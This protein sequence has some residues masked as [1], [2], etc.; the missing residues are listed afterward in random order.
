MI[1]GKL[2]Y[3]E[4]SI[5][6]NYCSS[7]V[8]EEQSLGEYCLAIDHYYNQNYLEGLEAYLVSK[9]MFIF[10]QHKSLLMYPH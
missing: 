3:I 9:S 8:L 7:F 6:S 5:W 4:V 10:E 2:D 1:D